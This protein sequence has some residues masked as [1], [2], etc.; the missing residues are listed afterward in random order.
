MKNNT[1][2]QSPYEL[3]KLVPPKL[4]VERHMTKLHT[5]EELKYLYDEFIKEMLEKQNKQKRREE[6]KE[7]IGQFIFGLSFTILFIVAL[8]LGFNV[9]MKFQGDCKNNSESLLFT[10]RK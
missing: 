10:P 1:R 8:H 7:E 6:L 5:K 9:C 2:N 4:P 3:R